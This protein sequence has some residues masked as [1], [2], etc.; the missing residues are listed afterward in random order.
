MPIDM[1]EAAEL[2]SNA[3]QND[4]SIG[5]QTAP[6]EQA[7]VQPT[8][9]DGT[10]DGAAGNADTFTKV[11]PDNLPEELQPYW[12][13][14]QAEFTRKTQALAEQ[15]KAY[16]ALGDTD[17]TQALE[18]LRFVQ[19]LQ[20]DPNVAQQV[21]AELTQALMQAGLTPAEAAHTAA[22]QMGGGNG[23]QFEPQDP[24]NWGEDDFA[25]GT[26]PAVEQKL[27]QFEQFIQQYHAQ[28]Q[29]QQRMF[30]I[31]RQD[32]FIRQQHPEYTQ[33]D[34]DRIYQLSSWHG[35]LINAEKEYAN[36][37]S[38]IVAGFLNEKKNVPVSG[39]RGGG[40]MAQAPP[41][42]FHTLDDPNL[43]AAVSAYLR[44]AE[45]NDLA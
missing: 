9:G 7:P 35:D 23:M 6:Q 28:Q 13:Q 20:T 17:P 41:E 42:G 45:A 8:Q 11:N 16:E 38:E 2:L 3:A 25:F 4:P 14:L 18:A 43:D 39:P 10:Q 40:G 33:T 1:A 27:N 44:A 12:K 34:I 24:N 19:A 15:R 21:H 37:R 36:M 22:A 26:D 32:N 29:E 30:E 5:G 31:Q